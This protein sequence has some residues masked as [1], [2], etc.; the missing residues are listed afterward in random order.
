[1]KIPRKFPQE[2]CNYI[3]INSG[4]MDQMVS[5]IGKKNKAFFLNCRTYKY[6]LINIPKNYLFNLIDSNID[7]KLRESSYN[8]RFN[9]LKKAQL[10]LTSIGIVLILITYF[11]YPMAKKGEILKI[12]ECN[13]LDLFA[14][15]GSFGIESLSRGAKSCCFIDSNYIHLKNIKENLSKLTFSQNIIILKGDI[16]KIEKPTKNQKN[17]YNVVFIDPPYQNKI[18]NLAIGN[19]LQNE[20]LAKDAIIIV[21]QHQLISPPSVAS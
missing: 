14:G 19:I 8:E 6:E 9:E 20:W 2:F 18:V 3:G 5:S 21:K 12:S 11:Y 4:I 10:I 16:T 13:V 1:M 17:I 15:I 7:R